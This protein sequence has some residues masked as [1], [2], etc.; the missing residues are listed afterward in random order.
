MTLKNKNKIIL[1]LTTV[2]LAACGGGSDKPSAVESDQ[3]SNAPR[4]E[5]PQL[6]SPV[7]SQCVRDSWVAGTTE[8]C[9]GVL[10]YYDYV[11]DDYGA[12][13]GLVSMDP[14]LLNLLNRG[15]QLGLPTANTPGLLSP[16][17]GDQRYP[18]GRENTADLVRLSLAIKQNKLIVMAELNT[19]FNPD[20]AILGVAIDTNPEG[21]SGG[22]NWGEINVSSDGWDQTY[23]AHHGDPDTNTLSLTAPLPEGEH[24]RIQA[25]VAKA[26]GTVMNVAFRGPHEE[27]KA[28]GGVNQVLPASGNFW[29]DR[30]AAELADGDI[31][32]FGQMVNVS[33][34]RNGVTQVA[35]KTTGFHQRVYTSAYPLGEGI[36]MPAEDGRDGGGLFCGQSFT[37]LGKYQPYG[38][39]VPEGDHADKPGMMVVM[40]GCEA[41]HAS[42]IN[43]TNMQRQFGDDLNRILVSPLGRGPYGFYTGPSERDVL[44]VMEDIEQAYDIDPDR[45]FASGYSMGGFGALHMATHYPDRFAGMVSWVGHTGDL[46]NK[47]SVQ[48][49]VDELLNTTSE[50]LLRPV[51]ASILGSIADPQT[52]TENV[53]DY[54]ENLRHVPSAHLYAGAD[55]LVPIHEAL[56]IAQRLSLTEGVEYYFYLHPVAEHLTLLLF[57]NWAKEAQLS[58]DWARVL[59]PS[60]VSYRFDPRFDYPDL[61]IIHDKAYWVSNLRARSVNEAFIDLSAPGCNVSDPAFDVGTGLG[62]SPLPWAGSYRLAEGV[63]P[64]APSLTLSGKLENVASATL[65]LESICLK[66]MAFYYDIDSDGPAVLELSDGRVL[67]LVAGKNEGLF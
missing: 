6:E 31:S 21:D 56:A 18:T 62:A 10:T 37:Y 59:N 26:D 53:I 35:E 17:A 28:D 12:D 16:A 15:G 49:L 25:A 67:N 52:G 3:I 11:Y 9:Q 41:N 20:D 45:I 30:Q 63:I 57:D 23:F 7:H 22:G 33:D 14:A 29:E 34:L 51:L 58:A 64:A 1:T 2:L 55:E 36:A 13:A 38:V 50:V 42:Q 61:D 48:P 66:G 5:T 4:D 19:M 27:A 60:R 65:D 44:D 46:I 54:L 32:A 47:P 40:H 39:Y 24:W 43:Q 8:L